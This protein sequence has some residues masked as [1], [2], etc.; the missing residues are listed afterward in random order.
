M[1]ETVNSE[2]IL[3]Q[4]VKLTEEGTL[5]PMEIKQMKNQQHKEHAQMLKQ[6]EAYKK[7]LKEDV[8]LLELEVK[9]FQY[10]LVLPDLRAKY[11]DKYYPKPQPVQQEVEASDKVIKAKE[12]GEKKLTITKSKKKTTELNP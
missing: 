6:R 8:G 12:L 9:F 10:S 4:E 2:T 3:D 5:T 11:E 7:N 1:T